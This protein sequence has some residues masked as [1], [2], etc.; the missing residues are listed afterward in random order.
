MF[1]LFFSFFFIK[2]KIDSAIFTVGD[3]TNSITITTPSS[4]SSWEVN[5]VHSISW[6]S[7]GSI[8]TVNIE[9]YEN[10]AFEQTIVSGTSNNGSYSWSIPSG[11]SDS[12][13]YQIK[14][15]D[16]SDVNVYDYSSSFEIKTDNPLPTSIPSY[17]LFLLLST[18]VGILFILIKKQLNRR[19][20]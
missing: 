10:G 4:F 14:I 5:T 15:I 9:L 1:S 11:L 6:S 19:T 18:I 8:S 17:D 7:T 16:S 12:T 3:T 13:Q 20:I 2:S